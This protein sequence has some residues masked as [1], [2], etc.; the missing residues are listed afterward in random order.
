MEELTTEKNVSHENE[1]EKIEEQEDPI[2]LRTKVLHLLGGMTVERMLFFQF[3]GL[4]LKSVA[5]SQM[6]L[7]K[8]CR[9]K[10]F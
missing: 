10:S 3:F 9:G 1:S 2:S 5:E 8:T 4:S 6:I 7:Y